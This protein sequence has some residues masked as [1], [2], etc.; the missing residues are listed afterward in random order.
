MTDKQE[1]LKSSMDRFIAT[2]T[3]RLTYH[4]GYLKSSMDRFIEMKKI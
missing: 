4:F 1:N 3:S 2:L